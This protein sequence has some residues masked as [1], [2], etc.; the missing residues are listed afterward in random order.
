MQPADP[1]VVHG[2]KK[3]GMMS[4]LRA[5]SN[6]GPLR[7]GYCSGGRFTI[8]MLCVHFNAVEES[9]TEAKYINRYVEAPWPRTGMRIGRIPFDVVS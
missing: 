4:I 6:E 9:H 8:H 3:H 5:A 2:V 7:S 1:Q